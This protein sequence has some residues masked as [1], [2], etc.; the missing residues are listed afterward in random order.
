MASILV[1]DDH[2]ASRQFLVTLLGYSGHRVLEAE[3]GARALEI[4]H[5]EHPA[6]VIADM[7]MPV[8]GG[9][10]LA[11]QLRAD[12][13]LDSIPIIFY[14]ATYR[15]SEARSLA[16]AAGVQYVL[17]KPAEPQAVL[18]LV[19]T[20]L[21]Q[22]PASGSPPQTIT[23]QLLN[24]LQVVSAKLT[25]KIGELGGVNLRLSELIA[26]GMEI[27]AERNPQRLL[28]K[29][30]ESARKILNAEYAA[31]RILAKDGKSLKHFITSGM[32]SETV[33]R[34]GSPP[35]GEGILRVLLNERQTIRLRDLTADPR[36]AGFPAGHPIMRSF[37][38]VPIMT[39]LQM[40]GILY[41]TEK[42]GAQEFSEEDEQLAITLASQVAVAYENAYL[43]DDIQRHAAN[44]QLEMTRRQQA[45]EALR[46]SEQLFSKIFKD[47]PVAISMVG[48]PG[49]KNIEVNDA[50]C[51][52]TGFS[53]EEAIGYDTGELKISDPEERNR[54]IKEFSNQGYSK[55]VESVINTKSGG[56]KNILIS[57]EL[58][59]IK[60]N[61]RILVSEID[62]TEHKR[63]E[64]KIERQLQRLNALHAI[65]IA[66]SSSFDVRVT[67]DV[68]L[69]QVLSQLEV[70]ASAILLLDA[71]TQTIEYALSHGFRSDALRYTQ[72]KLGEGYAGR[73]VLE[74]KT[75]HISDLMETGGKRANSLFLE[76]ESFVDY[77]GAPLI[78]KGEVKGVL[79]IY[80]R[81]L[82][83][84]DPE[85]LEFLEILAGQAAIAIDNAQL[86]NGLQRANADLERRV[87]E[88]T[89]ELNR[90]NAELEHANRAKDEFLATMSH[91]LRTP[92]NSILGLSES[93]LEQRRGSLNDNQEKS[94]HIIES[95][96]RHLL[97]LINDI[98]DLSKIEAGKID[99]H[100]QSIGVDDLCRASL[101]F[102]KEQAARKSITLGYQEEPTVAKMYADPRR[103]K[104]ILVNLLT[105]AVKFT[106]DNGQVILQVRGDVEQDRIQ[107]SIMDTGIGIALK[108]LRLL[109]V[110]FSQVDSTLTR[111]YEGTGLGLALVQKLTDLH[112][113]SV[114]V[115][116]EVGQGSRFTIHLPIGQ[117]MVAQQGV[118]ESADTI[119][120]NEQTE[121]LN[122]PEEVERRMVLLAEDN[123]ANILTIGDYLESQG[124]QVVVAQDG[125]S[126]MQKAEALQPDVILMDIQMPVLDGLEAI[127]RLRALPRFKTTPIIALTALAM[128]GDRES[129]LEAGA[130]EYVSKPASLKELV[131]NIHQLLSKE[132]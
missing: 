29:F 38:G 87:A 114:Q 67:L 53:R 21:G 2:P 85:W 37:L 8:M 110:P 47:S 66:I 103:L 6:L 104:Q 34:L 118:I 23:K 111:E 115:E 88:R 92:L 60:E 91:E 112:G 93:L 79:E 15:E 14:T 16:K 116:S 70:D 81:S 42:I 89:T 100:P 46:E 18:D 126:A 12:R 80:H 113:G 36:S 68:A 45:E 129:C 122:I 107:F 3:N 131:K 1:V 125:L 58:I 74:R 64:E 101:A 105:N 75:T 84:P 17:N 130:N 41:L 117:I 99:F 61:Q 11:R 44:L 76:G 98:L 24:P 52:L 40:Y 86:F 94:L 127:R 30:C 4:A 132:A 35:T 78:V 72:L 69:Q 128:P 10:E 39:S 59:T 50:W 73:A 56:K 65:D 25:A 26:L 63:A 62:I 5:A 31:V 57:S 102:V 49:G 106:P 109:F 27:G 97:E 7:L 9:Y 124:Y 20:A 48:V 77:Y 108:D 96:G 55:L 54:L 123:K 51:N 95:S 71:Q 43:Y 119:P 19:N 33:A 90:I 82:L 120:G 83:N 32:D 121:E 22:I 13:D 28:E